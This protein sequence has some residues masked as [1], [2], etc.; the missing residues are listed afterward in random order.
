MIQEIWELDLKGC[1]I[2]AYNQGFIASFKQVLEHN[3]KELGIFLSYYYKGEGGLVEEVKFM[4]PLSLSSPI[5]GHFMVSYKVI[6]YNACWDIHQENREE[7]LL[8]FDLQTKQNKLILTGPL[9][10]ER[11]PD[12]I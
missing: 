8:F 1:Q 6:Y 11:E 10:P 9:W 5:S 12:E 4:D 3:E 7:M 2:K